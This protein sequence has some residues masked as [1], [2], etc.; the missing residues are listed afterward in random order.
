M[1][2]TTGVSDHPTGGGVSRGGARRVGSP[3]SVG[4][5]KAPD[6]PTWQDPAARAR[7]DQ[8]IT[9]AALLLAVAALGAIL[10]GG[11]R[12]RSVEVQGSGLPVAAIVQT[13]SVVGD[14]LFTVRSDQVA[15]RLARLPAI[16]VVRVST[17]LP[18][19]VVIVARR[20]AAVAAW[21]PPSG[22]ELLAADGT[23]IGQVKSTKLPVVVGAV[24]PSAAQLAAVRYARHSLG[25]KIAAYRIGPVFGLTI[26]GQ[27]G[28]I[29]RVGSGAPQ[30]M[31]MRVATLGALLEK[32][33]RHGEHLVSVDLRYRNPYFRLQP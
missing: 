8:L 31:V 20:R 16:T 32:L 2:D 7:R 1:S 4:G 10:G 27:D 19:R 13:S 18:D 28:W 12:V 15:A 25:A 29:A 11:F 3:S 17:E 30:T 6:A 24:H 5:P 23:P 22:L 9:I 33:A 14:N 26:A 21:Q